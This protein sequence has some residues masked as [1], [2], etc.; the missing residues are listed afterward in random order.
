MEKRSERQAKFLRPMMGKHVRHRDFASQEGVPNA[1]LHEVRT[2]E[3]QCQ[4][5]DLSYERQ[6]LL[7]CIRKLV[8]WPIGPNTLWLTQ[9]D[10]SA[11]AFPVFS[12]NYAVWNVRHHRD[13]VAKIL[14]FYSN[15]S[16]VIS[17]A[18]SE[19]LHCCRIF[20]GD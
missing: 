8:V 14:K 19:Q 2:P 6:K 3:Q 18:D 13:Y 1:K 9:R 4:P 20:S 16:G 5:V 12:T 15:G 11:S 7:V 17:S 10:A